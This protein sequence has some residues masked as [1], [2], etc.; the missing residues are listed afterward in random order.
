MVE[1][2]IM[3]HS[4]VDYRPGVAI[5]VDNPLTPLG[6]RLA[7]RLGERSVAWRLQHL[8]SSTMPRA[9]QTAEAVLAANPGLRCTP[10]EGLCETSLADMSGYAG[11]EPPADLRD[12][13]ADHYLYGNERM[14]ERVRGAWNEILATIRREGFERVGIV[15]HGGSINM[16]LRLFQGFDDHDLGGCWF[17]MDWTAVSVLEYRHDSPRRYIRAVNDARHVEP[18]RAEIDAFASWAGSR[19]VD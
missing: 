15:A 1:V 13:D 11:P 19:P 3:R 4:H 18:L 5:G 17:E 7:A 2:Y 14:L 12:W 10:L 8:F 9:V 16:L 6:H